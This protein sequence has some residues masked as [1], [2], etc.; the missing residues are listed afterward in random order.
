M[1][2]FLRRFPSIALVAI[3]LLALCA[4][5]SLAG[6]PSAFITGT[7]T[8]DGKPVAGAVVKAAGNNRTVE[9]KTGADGHFRFPPL[10]LGSYLLSASYGKAGA[11]ARVDLTIGGAAITIPLGTLKQIATVAVRSASTVRGSGGDVVLN[12]T[13]LTEMPYNNS[14]PE[15]MIQLPGAA[16][17]ANGVVHMNGDHGVIDFQLDGVMLPEELNRDIGGEINLNDV[18]YISLMEGAYPAQYGLKFGSVFNISTRAGT[19]PAGFDGNVSYGSYATVNSTLGFHSPLAGG[20]GYDIAFSGMETDR[21]LDPPD[22]N[23]PHND[24]SSAN[25]FARFTLPSGG[26]NYTNVTFVHSTATFQIPNDV[27]GGEP[28]DTDD[29]E[30][31][32][33]VFLSMQFHHAIGDVG[34]WN[35]GP[36]FKSSNIQDFGDAPGDFA[37][38]EAVNLTPPPY[39]NGGT[40]ADCAMNPNPNY[41]P[42][43]C[44][45][46]LNDNR[47]AF[48]YILQSDFTRI[49]GNH[50][51]QAGATYDGTLVDK[52]YAVTLQPGNFLAPLLTPGTPDAPATVID[53]TPNVGNTYTA[54]A[55]DSWRITPLWE[56]DYG[57]RYDFFTIKSTTFFQGFGSTSPRLKLTR[58]Y[59]TRASVYAYIG[60]FFEP[61]SFENVGPE[62]AYLLNIPLQCHLP[63]GAPLSDCLTQPAAQFDLKP[64]RDTDLEL[65]GHLPIGNGDLGLR[66][67]QK[68][69]N[70]LIDDTQVGVTALHQDINYVLGRISQEALNYTLPLPR[71]GRAYVAFAHLLS[72]NAG[73]ETQLLAPCYGQPTGFTPA[74]HEQIW[75]VNSGVLLRDKR[76]GWYSV[77]E[78]YGSGLSSAV[79]PSQILFCSQTPHLTFSA[80]KGVAIGPK[81]ALTFDIQNLLNDRYYVTLL[82]AQGNHY[83]PPR[84]FSMGVRFQP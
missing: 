57:M 78:E 15:M 22:F 82:N 9:T 79:C 55:Q 54:Y 43:T 7:V 35:F 59:G 13:T 23:S 29:N 56:A 53:D 67:W 34:A 10:T 66:V 75:T 8:Q 33:D 19:G 38:G 58:F 1:E 65:G 74:D 16:R 51:F 18:S 4:A 81:T 37:Y 39:G 26:D 41:L 44:A 52:Y 68:N 46:S 2:P 14:F 71:N 6:N 77:D 20:G 12:S 25:Q 70:D 28:A 42:T 76:G 50:T 60:R 31:Q 61:P 72:L 73:C 17:G 48:D 5:P 45:V 84:T 24:A 36:A 80:E 32:E 62:A 11:E 64:E 63:T 83:A 40:P 30:N 3:A 49:Y 21:G 27:Q 47:T 69:A